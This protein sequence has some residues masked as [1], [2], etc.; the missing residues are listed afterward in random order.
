VLSYAEARDADLFVREADEPHAV[1]AADVRQGSFG[2]C[3]MLAPLAALAQRRPNF[4]AR[5]LRDNRDGTYTV[6]FYPTGPRRCGK[7]VQVT[8]D[9]SLP[10][11]L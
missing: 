9:G 8:V 10:S 3:Y 5:N 2:D 6:T 1:S 11:G 4:I 7:A